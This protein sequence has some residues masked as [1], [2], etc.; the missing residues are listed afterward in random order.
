MS[1]LHSIFVIGGRKD[2]LNDELPCSG[3]N[4]RVVSKVSMFEQNTIIL[5]VDADSILD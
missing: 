1:Y 4:D 5:F 3:N 2:L